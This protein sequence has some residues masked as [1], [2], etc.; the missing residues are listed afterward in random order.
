MNHGKIRAG[1]PIPFERLPWAAP[2][3]LA[4]QEEGIFDPDESDTFMRPTCGTNGNA[5]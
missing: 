1:T 4:P 5:K 2:V 3:A